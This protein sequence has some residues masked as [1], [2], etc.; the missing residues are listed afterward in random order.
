[1]ST[2]LRISI[3]GAGSWGTVIANMVAKNI[4]RDIYLWLRDKDICKEINEKKTNSKYTE[5]LILQKNIKA[6]TNLKEV[7]EASNI[8]IITIPY[9]Y[10][11]NFIN[12]V[13]NMTS[14]KPLLGILLSKGMM[15]IKNK[16]YPLSHYIQTLLKIPIAYLSGPNVSK[17]VANKEPCGATIG[18]TIND[19]NINEILM[20]I[21]NN[22][23]F[24][25]NIVNCIICIEIFASVKNVIALGSGIIDG[26]NYH[27]NTKAT[28]ISRAINEMIKFIKFYF[29]LTSPKKMLLEDCGIADIIA[30]SYGGRNRLCAEKF[31]TINKNIN[32][33]EKTI[34][35]GQKLQ[36]PQVCSQI[37]DILN[38][39]N[40]LKEF[41]LFKKIY[42]IIF[43]KNDP[44]EI[45]E[46][47]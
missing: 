12:K 22:D 30:T 36:G 34:L 27:S 42:E 11:I 24:K 21:F 1:M 6:S 25:I 15:V 47:I 14:H 31:I 45:L 2:D 10:V 35:N 7:Y 40:I 18:I 38:N 28:F 3:F 39:D 33:I 46:I 9:P 43:L 4:N 29:P 32:T 20:K 26:L 23:Y 16:P 5:N 41:P 17:W 44:L 8:I 13:K 19:N 37:Y